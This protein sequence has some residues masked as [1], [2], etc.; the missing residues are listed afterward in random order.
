MS[1]NS[2]QH[3]VV[4]LKLSWI[5]GIDNGIFMVKFLFFPILDE[6]K[7]N[8]ALTK[9]WKKVKKNRSHDHNR[10]WVSKLSAT[11]LWS[12]PSRHFYSY[13]LVSKCVSKQD[14]FKKYIFYSTRIKMIE[15]TELKTWTCQ[16]VQY[17]YLYLYIF[18][19]ICHV[20]W[21]NSEILIIHKE[22]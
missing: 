22:L 17:T 5:Y 18:F 14:I 21:K 1:D 6:Q 19:S 13:K 11:W 9:T 7:K 12:N 8:P 16:M 3:T 4:L 2:V 15:T 20:S 10:K